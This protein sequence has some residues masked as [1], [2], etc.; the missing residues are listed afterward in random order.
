MTQSEKL[1][2]KLSAD[3]DI[4]FGPATPADLE[5]LEGLKVPPEIV[6][7]YR[8]FEP[9][10]YVELGEVRLWPIGDILRE[11]TNYV[12]GCDLIPHGYIVFASNLFGDSYCFDINQMNE[13][14]QAPVVLMAHDEPWSEFDADYIAEYIEEAR[15]K[16]ADNLEDF[17][18]KFQAETLETDPSYEEE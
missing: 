7:F 14:G 3:T 10:E 16:V 12:P 4:A 6:S 9:Q 8:R 5:A 17:L 15:L 18:Q 1:V 2:E 11:N 13:S